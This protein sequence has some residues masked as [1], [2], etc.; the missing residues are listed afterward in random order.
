MNENVGARKVTSVK[1]K[2]CSTAPGQRP[3]VRFKV[4]GTRRLSCSSKCIKKSWT[5]RGARLFIASH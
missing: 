1:D 4:T 2:P 5:R 3:R